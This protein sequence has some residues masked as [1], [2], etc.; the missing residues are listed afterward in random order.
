MSRYSGDETQRHAGGRRP[1]HQG[2]EAYT[3]INKICACATIEHIVPSHA[4]HQLVVAAKAQQNLAFRIRRPG[5][6]CCRCPRLSSACHPR[7]LSPK[8]YARHPLWLG[9]LIPLRS[10]VIAPLPISRGN[11]SCTCR[12]IHYYAAHRTAVGVSKPRCLL[13]ARRCG[14]RGRCRDKI[15]V[16]RDENRGQA[17]GKTISTDQA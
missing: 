15:S 12:S 7:Y 5:C 16:H 10:V 1:E 13:Q 2:V 11:R 17:P 6:R 4:A 3:A 9:R 8:I 14:S